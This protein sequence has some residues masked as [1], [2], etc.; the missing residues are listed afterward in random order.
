M[1]RAVIRLFKDARP[2]G[3]WV[4]LANES[5]L[6][7][8]ALLFGSLSRSDDVEIVELWIMPH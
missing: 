6:R 8:A 7:A 3:W 5:M 1:I 2:L 4:P